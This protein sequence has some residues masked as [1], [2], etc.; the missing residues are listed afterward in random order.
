LRFLLFT[1]S[2]SIVPLFTPPPSGKGPDAAFG[3]ILSNTTENNTLCLLVTSRVALHIS[4]EN[5][6][7]VPPLTVPDLAPLPAYEALTKT[8]AVMLFLQRCQAVQPGFQ[9]T[10]GNASTIAAI[11]ARLDGLPLA[12]ELA[13]ARIKLLPPQALLKRLER[14]LTV[15]TGGASD[16]PVRHQALRNALQWSYDLLSPEEQ[17]LFRRLSVFAG[18]FTLQAAEALCA[19]LDGE[20]G[21]G[22]PVLDGLA[23]LVEKSLVQ[24][25]LWDEEDPRLHMLETIREY[26]LECL[27][28]NG[29]L[30]P[31]RQA[32]A[33][34]FL[35]LAEEAAPH[36]NRP[37]ETEDVWIRRLERE[38]ENIRAAMAWSLEYGRQTRNMEIALRLV[39]ALGYFWELR[40]YLRE[41]WAFT[42]QT[43]TGCE[44][45]AAR[46]QASAF[47]MASIFTRHLGELEKSERMSE[48]SLAFYRE[49][50]DTA[51]I[52]EQLR[53]LGY[54]AQLRFD[55]E[56]A[57]AL[58]EESL[59]LYTSLND[60]QGI[61]QV[62]FNLAY[63]ALNEGDYQ[64][65]RVLFERILANRRRTGHQRAIASTLFQLAQLLYLS[66]TTPPVEEIQPLLNE[67]LAL[68]RE[69]G[70]M[71]NNAAFQGLMAVV[72]FRQGDLHK[73]RQ[74]VE[75]AIQFCRKESMQYLLLACLPL[76]ARLNTVEGDYSA[77]RAQFEESL[78]IARRLNQVDAISDGLIGMAG[79][80]IAQQQ[81]VRAA[82][83]F[84]A[85]EKIREAARVSIY[86]VDRPI[87]DRS[88]AAVRVFLGEKALTA[89]WGEG[90]ALSLAEALA[91]S[92]IVASTQQ[93]S[94]TPTAQAP[95]YPA[96]L[97][98]REVEV[99]RLVAQGL[100]DAQ[101]AEKLVVSPRTVTTHLT[102][103]YNKLGVNSRVAATRFAVE[104]QLG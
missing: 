29:E 61:D 56:R 87:Y 89:L 74:L 103:I 18:G 84:G 40:G 79:L 94:K 101:V 3:I 34:C 49:L 15:L 70:D 26:G 51:N 41:G 31:A 99:L 53:S 65:S 6:F 50:G 35:A 33:Q 63:L 59:A 58:Y 14:R 8:A 100:S 22:S 91:A 23:S 48:R 83:L 78:T 69:V 44:G 16:L 42:E 64:H 2:P 45:V 32:H 96:G 102:S 88:V 86:P 66:H 54:R 60:Q 92:D 19:A 62:H 77:A 13:A 10:P 17:Q 25:P 4:S 9:L 7:L 75:E 98:A 80:A 43:L 82:R 95:P 93:G 39:A 1:I 97:T 11:C 76:L 85:D 46:V 52:A 12:I 57:H 68:S 24:S 37:Q 36:L 38:V 73:A 47:N 81:Y 90:R 67:G 104:H 5:E 55:F 72:A 27:A 28:A 71:Q 20:S 21:T 30:E